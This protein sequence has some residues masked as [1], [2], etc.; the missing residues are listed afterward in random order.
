MSFIKHIRAPIGAAL[1]AALLAACGGGGS[2]DAPE[3]PDQASPI[4]TLAASPQTVEGGAFVTLTASATD[5]TGALLTPGLSCD[6]GTLQGSMLLTPTVTENTDITCTATATDANGRSGDAQAAITVTATVAALELAEGQENLTPGQ[7]AVLFA[8]A[9]P[10]E[11]ERY[12][13]TLGGTPVTLYNQ[14]GGLLWFLVPVDATAGD[15]TLQ[16]TL[17][18]RPWEF[19][20]EL[21]AAPSIADPR[22][23]VRA[24]LESIDADLAVLEDEH[25][26]GMSATEL[27]TLQTHRSDL[28]EALA[29]LDT[30]DTADEAS[31]RT[32]AQLLIASGMAQGDAPAMGSGDIQAKA[33]STGGCGDAI[34]KASGSLT[35]LA[36]MLANATIGVKG[37]VEIPNPYIKLAGAGLA[38]WSFYEIWKM[39]DEGGQLK[40]GLGNIRSNCI[41]DPILALLPAP[42]SSEAEK[43]AR[44]AFA[45]PI[46]ALT[47]KATQ[48]LAFN[49]GEPLYFRP[50]GLF[51]IHEDYLGSVKTLFRRIGTTISQLPVIPDPLAALVEELVTEW[52]EAVPPGSISIGRISSDDIAIGGS[53]AGVGE[54]LMLEFS[55]EDAE[56]EEEVDFSFTLTHSDAETPFDAT[57]S[58]DLPEAEDAAFEVIQGIATSSSVTTVGADTLEIVASP[59]HGSVQLENDGSFVFTPSGQYFGTDQFT[60][61]ARN[62]NG[63]SRV[64][65]V[66]ISIK[67]KFDGLWSIQMNRTLTSNSPSGLCEDEPDTTET[68]AISKVSDTLYQATY[69]G[70]TINLKMS[71]ADDAGG[72]SGALSGSYPDGPDDEGETTES[73]SLKVPDSTHLH[74]TLI[75][76]YSGPNGSCAGNTVLTGTRAPGPF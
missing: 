64:A 12:E 22:A 46:K 69:L 51:K 49:N 57:L 26:A 5:A 61:R 3:T 37:A 27:E 40:T 43:S 73:L 41:V 28:A 11:D 39:S 18:G 7:I 48:K 54:L 42:A 14:G 56:E 16:A 36:Y 59:A 10:L 65:T 38:A 44:A 71:S 34:S 50:E 25:G 8:D 70:E 21:G 76:S 23:I 2:K 31:L 32:A 66:A 47:A 4:V 9:L 52:T 55:A 62:E 67:R 68:H 24:A 35:K 74:G 45:M 60:Y 19:P 29:L 20:V 33:S 30:P 13:A 17:N 72:L 63:H 6:Q 1:A 58:I 75:W 53:A 15:T